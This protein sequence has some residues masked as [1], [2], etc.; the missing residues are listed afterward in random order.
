VSLDTLAAR[1]C[2][3]VLQQSLWRSRA[4]NEPKRFSA[5]LESM[6][7]KRASATVEVVG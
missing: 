3:R 7:A 4:E 5:Q 2:G 6:C 1:L